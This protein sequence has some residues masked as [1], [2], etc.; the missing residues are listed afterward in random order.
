MRLWGE[1]TMALFSKLLCVAYKRFQYVACHCSCFPSNQ[2]TYSTEP[3]RNLTGIAIFLPHWCSILQKNGNCSTSHSGTAR[4]HAARVGFGGDAISLTKGALATG[5]VKMPGKAGRQ[6]LAAG[7]NGVWPKHERPQHQTRF[8][9]WE[10]GCCDQAIC[11]VQTKPTTK[12]Q[13]IRERILPLCML[14]QTKHLGV[15]EHFPGVADFQFLRHHGHHG[16][17]VARNQF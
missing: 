2:S 17:E 11:P 7:T 9:G 13:H 14:H 10:T 16:I 6:G 4:P 5:T 15:F 8:S 3:K 12:A 1:V